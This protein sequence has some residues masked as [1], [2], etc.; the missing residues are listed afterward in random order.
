MK[1]DVIYE[2]ITEYPVLKGSPRSHRQNIYSL[3]KD[4]VG[5]SLNLWEDGAGVK[6]TAS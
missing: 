5:S 6:A 1:D 4:I 3:R 2:R